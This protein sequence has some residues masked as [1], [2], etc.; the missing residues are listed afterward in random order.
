MDERELTLISDNLGLASFRRKPE[1]SCQN[2]TC[3]L[4]IQWCLPGFQLESTPHLR[5][6]RNDDR[7]T[8]VPYS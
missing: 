4:L 7:E 1:S 6:G 8:L 2:V 5:R 3:R